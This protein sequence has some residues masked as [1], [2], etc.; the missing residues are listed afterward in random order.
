MIDETIENLRRQFHVKVNSGAD[1]K[2]YMLFNHN[3]IQY[4][5]P[6]S[7]KRIADALPFMVK[8]CQG[9][10]INQLQV[11]EL[12]HLLAGREMFS[13][14]NAI[15]IYRRV[16]TKDGSVAILLDNKSGL[17]A[18]IDEECVKVENESQFTFHY[19]RTAESLPRPQKFVATGAVLKSFRILTG[20]SKP[21]FVN[22]IVNLLLALTS[23]GPF[24]VVEITGDPDLA[25]LLGSMIKA[26]IDPE[27]GRTR[28]IPLRES[29]LSASMGNTHT[30]AYNA[31]ATF[32]P[33]KILD[34]ICR[35]AEGCAS[36]KSLGYADDDEVIF[37]ASRFFV[38]IGDVNLAYNDGL[39]RRLVLLEAGGD[40]KLPR[41]RE[42][43]VRELFEEF[44]P[45]LLRVLFNAIS[46]GLK[47]IKDF[48]LAE[49][50]NAPDN[51]VL[52]IA[53]TEYF[54]WPLKF[55]LRSLEEN[56]KEALFKYADSDIIVPA[57]VSLMKHKNL[58]ECS[59]TDLFE[60]LQEHLDEINN[61]IALKSFPADPAALG[62]RLRKAEE[63]LRVYGIECV[64]THPHGPRMVL[65]RR[66]EC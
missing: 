3:N 38:L 1:G 19:S 18:S 43:K 21:H 51:L 50:P 62:K 61:R 55:V 24:P 16:A 8:A 36:T 29:D 48:K 10:H 28:N 17:V 31:T 23:T 66:I 11:K 9:Q 60:M 44:R 59:P 63:A 4:G 37:W 41:M 32:I 46:H 26:I 54:K 14:G 30:I 64:C 49:L 47:I 33:P 20:L 5:I 53:C 22:L 42:G 45:K 39:A 40:K 7:S 65:L 6:L 34:A 52:A 13:S 12:V 35:H 57:I 56:K 25:S 15:D 2:V 27:A 58:I